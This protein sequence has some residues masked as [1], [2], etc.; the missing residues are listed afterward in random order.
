MRPA[1]QCGCDHETAYVECLACSKLLINGICLVFVFC[2][3]FV[4][5]FVFCFFF[6]F[7]HL[8]GMLL[9]QQVLSVGLLRICILSSLQPLEGSKMFQ[10][11]ML[12]Y[13]TIQNSKAWKQP[14][15]PSTDET[16]KTIQY[17]YNGISLGFKKE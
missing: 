15:H 12:R 17:I 13:V 16:I 4:F 1:L 9:I 14:K 3:F 5:F 6:V 10:L 8:A 11:K 2:F 7:F